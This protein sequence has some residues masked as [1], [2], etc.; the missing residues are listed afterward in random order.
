[1]IAAIA[2]SARQVV[3][4]L[5]VV[6]Q[7][8]GVARPYSYEGKLV[9]LSCT[10]PTCQQPGRYLPAVPDSGQ[11][12][13]AYVEANSVSIE[14]SRRLQNTYEMVYNCKLVIW[15]NAAKL[16]YTAC[17]GLD[18]VIWKALNC[19]TAEKTVSVAHGEVVVKID[20][21]QASINT[22][23]VFRPYSYAD[24]P[25]LLAWP[26]QAFAVTYQATVLAP[27]KCL[28]YDIPDPVTCVT[29]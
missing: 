22:A 16:G 15:Y 20:R 28:T 2:E 26:Y 9:P 11:S 14:R 13:V 18:A 24:K 7:W 6:S 1:M 4:S 21:A 25:A 12:G 10:S 23:E 19:L 5:G 3:A 17:D 27:A 29:V 8:H